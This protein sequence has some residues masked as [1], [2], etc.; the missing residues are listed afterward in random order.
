MGWL[1]TNWDNFSGRDI[2]YPVVKYAAVEEYCTDSAH[3]TK[4]D[5]E[6]FRC[7][8]ATHMTDAACTGASPPGMWR[9]DAWWLAGSDEC[10]GS[11]GVTCGDVIEGQD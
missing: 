5:C 6:E 2:G 1:T 9:R 7:S 4:T 8:I 3:S 11:T 10:D